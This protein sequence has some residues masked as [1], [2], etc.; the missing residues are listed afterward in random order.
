MGNFFS[1]VKPVKFFLTLILFMA[2]ANGNGQQNNTLF[3]MHSLPE[4]NYLNPAVQI[5]CGVFIGLPLVSSFHMNIANSGFTA[6]KL[7][8]VYTDGTIGRSTETKMSAFPVQKYFLSEFH[9]VLLAVGIKRDDTY[10]SFTITEKDNSMLIYTSDLVDFIQIG[11]EPFEGNSVELKGTRA[12]FN[13]YREFALGVSKKYSSNLTLG[14]KTKLLFGKFNFTTGNSDFGLFVEEGTRDILFRIDGGFNS[15]LPYTLVQEGPN[16]YRFQDTYGAP[17]GKQL[18]NAKNPGLAIDLGFIYKYNDQWTFSGSL[19]DLGFIWYRSN[20]THYTLQ[21]N[22]RYQGPFARGPITNAYLWDV[23]DDLNANMDEVLSTDPYVYYLDPRLYL[24]ASRKLNNT[25]DLNFLLYN[26][27]LPGRLQTGATVSLLTRPDKAFRTSIS[28]SYMNASPANLGIG[29]SYGKRP[30][31]I[32][33]VTDNVFGFIL[34]MSTKNVNVRFGFNLRF[35]CR[36]SF[37][38]EQC[39]CGWLRAERDKRARIEKLK[40]RKQR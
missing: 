24:G 25:Y 32:Y 12:A 33:A 29:V 18:M 28:W 7:I 38:M 26:R 11:S 22:E 31:Q 23:F 10:Y 37:D 5:D 36:E 14:A 35:G 27:L 3:F 17:L 39:G 1:A 16:R 15:S 13:H 30:V 9:S 6:N 34:P 4:A 8:T 20:L 40:H 19:L 2:F 21:G